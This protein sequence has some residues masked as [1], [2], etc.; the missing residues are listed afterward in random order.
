LRLS[1]KQAV[2]IEGVKNRKLFEALAPSSC[3]LAFNANRASKDSRS[4]QFELF[5]IPSYLM[6]SEFLKKYYDNS[7]TGKEMGS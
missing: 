7:E 6:L 2:C 5:T 4:E 3:D 1:G